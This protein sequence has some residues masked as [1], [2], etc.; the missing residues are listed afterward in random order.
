MPGH[1]NPWLA[2]QAGKLVAKSPSESFELFLKWQ[3][4]IYRLQHIN[5]VEKDVEN[6]RVLE[7]RVE[8][9]EQELAA[10]DIEVSGQSR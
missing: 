8:P 2:H 10:R 4:H 1:S 7:R 5:G 3:D 9:T 6:L